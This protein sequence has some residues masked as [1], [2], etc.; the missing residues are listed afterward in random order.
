MTYLWGLGM[1]RKGWGGYEGTGI[2]G[3]RQHGRSQESGRH[4]TAW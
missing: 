1:L 4:K 2:A 3:M